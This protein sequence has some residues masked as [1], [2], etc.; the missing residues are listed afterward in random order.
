MGIGRID[1]EFAIREGWARDSD[2]EVYMD[3]Y[4]AF[5]QVTTRDGTSGFSVKND[6][7]AVAFSS[8]SD[9]DGYVAKDLS[10]CEKTTTLRLQVSD[11][12]TEGYVLTSDAVGNATWQPISSGQAL[13]LNLD[14]YLTGE[15]ID[16]YISGINI[17]DDGTPVVSEATTINFG[18]NLVVTNNGAGKVTVDSTGDASLPPGLL[19]GYLTDNEHRGLD[20]LVHRISEDSYDEFFYVGLGR[21]GRIITWTDSNK[22]TKI[23]ERIIEYSGVKIEKVTTVQYGASGAEVERMV[24]DYTYNGFRI[25]KVTRTVTL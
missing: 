24:E 20:Q 22:T 21:I 23:R 4:N 10:V 11:G 7:G 19:D 16:G 9:G 12:A 8:R 25:D 14:G 1:P 15:D 18:T 6:I 17:Q 3:G 13:N 2:D 5:I